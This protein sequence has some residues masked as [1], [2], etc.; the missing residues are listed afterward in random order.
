MDAKNIGYYILNEAANPDLADAKVVSYSKVGNHV[1]AEG[2]LQEVGVKN[3]NG[4]IYLKE[5]LEPE[6][7]APRQ[8]E[9]FAAKQMKG[10]MGHPDPSKGGL[11]RQQTIDPTMTCVQFLDEFWMEGDIVRGRFKGTNNQLGEYFNADILEGAKPAFSLRALGSIESKGGQS[12]VKN[13]KLITY[14]HVIYPSHKPAY[15]TNIVSATNESASLIAESSNIFVVD[16]DYSGLAVPITQKKVIEYVKEESKNLKQVIDTLELVYE[17]IRL[18]DNGNQVIL[19][20][21]NGDKF[22]V[23]LESYIRNDIMDFCANYR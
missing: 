16:E 7:H 14:D 6:L 11:S 21:V 19:E 2:N 4:R 1:I 3:R 17:N 22:I 12:Y 8:K 18:A 10:E 23:N 15:M 5:D 13:L 20:H 9:L